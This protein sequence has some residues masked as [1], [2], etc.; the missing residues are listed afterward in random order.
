MQRKL[1]FLY[2]VACHAL[3]LGVYGWMAAFVGD[4]SFGGLIPTIDGPRDGSLAL[5]LAVNALL[6]ALFGVQ[7]SVMARPGFK[8]WWTKFIPQPIERAT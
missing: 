4:F 1:F 6:I 8:A 5:A 7:H 2:G 3:F